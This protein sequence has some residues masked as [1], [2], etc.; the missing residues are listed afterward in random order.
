MVLRVLMERILLTRFTKLDDPIRAAFF[1]ATVMSV[2][3][4]ILAA[5]FP[6]DIP[7]S[8]RL[9]ITI[10]M[11]GLFVIQFSKTFL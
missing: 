9:S 4:V 2:T 5:T 6:D 7:E 11:T 8:V 10:L 1:H 3:F